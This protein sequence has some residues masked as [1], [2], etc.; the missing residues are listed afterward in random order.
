[1]ITKRLHWARRYDAR[2][3]SISRDFYDTMTAAIWLFLLSFIGDK[4]E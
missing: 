4:Q 2:Y 3:D 1:M